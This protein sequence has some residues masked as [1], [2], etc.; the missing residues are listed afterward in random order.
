MAEPIEVAVPKESK[1]KKRGR[2]DASKE[3]R[4]C[5]SSENIALIDDLPEVSDCH[6]TYHAI[7]EK[8]LHSRKINLGDA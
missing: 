5:I 8:F 7:S 2:K 4:K 3:S 1:R 6:G